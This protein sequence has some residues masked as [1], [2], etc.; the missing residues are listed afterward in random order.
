MMMMGWMTFDWMM[1]IL[2]LAGGGRGLMRRGGNVTATIIITGV[3]ID[4]A[5]GVGVEVARGTTGED[6][7][8]TCTL[9]SPLVS[10]CLVLIVPLSYLGSPTPY[11]PFHNPYPLGKP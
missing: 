2:L 3:I 7:T 6:K 4:I 10:C 1:M 9:C 11:L 5:A 8:I